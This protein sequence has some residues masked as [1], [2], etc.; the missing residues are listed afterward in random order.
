MSQSEIVELG[1]VNNMRVIPYPG[2]DDIFGLVLYSAHSDRHEYV[3]TTGALRVLWH[4]LTQLLF[5]QAALQIAGRA[6]TAIISP[7]RTLTTTYAVKV[8]TL[9]PGDWIEVIAVSAVNG[10]CCRFNK[11]EALNL[12]ATLESLLHIVNGVDGAHP[13]EAHLPQA[14]VNRL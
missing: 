1:K 7:G 4:C 11:E 9:E 10:W 12:W 5:P 13:D 3:I 8:R 6:P 14:R 2:A